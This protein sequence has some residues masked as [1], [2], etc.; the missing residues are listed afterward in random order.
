[1][2]KGSD[3]TM[4]ATGEDEDALNPPIVILPAAVNATDGAT[5]RV[6]VIRDDVLPGGTK[7]RALCCML[8]DAAAV[9]FVYA[10]DTQERFLLL[11]DCLDRL[12]DRLAT[13]EEVICFDLLM[14][15]V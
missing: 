4:A 11:F 13:C 7:Q 8:R 2:E 12:P 14:F 15:V 6:H 10:G 5:F 9:E 3:E 1:M